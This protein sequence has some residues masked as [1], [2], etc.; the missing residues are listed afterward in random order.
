ML[1]E[2]GGGN[3]TEFIDYRISFQNIVI[4]TIFINE[5]NNN[6]SNNTI[7]DDNNNE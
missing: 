7:S 5:D 4:V 6:D 1:I 2:V 3:M